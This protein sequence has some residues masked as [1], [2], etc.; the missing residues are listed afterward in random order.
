[1]RLVM[2]VPVFG[3]AD[4]GLGT[5]LPLAVVDSSGVAPG[6]V[7]KVSKSRRRPD[8]TLRSSSIR[9]AFVDIFSEALSMSVTARHRAVA[10]LTAALVS[11]T[12]IGLTASSAHA[13]PVSAPQSQILVAAQFRVAGAIG[14]KWKSL[15]G[16]KSFLGEPINSERRLKT[17]GAYQ[18]FQGGS[19][20]WSSRTGAHA[21]KGA[22]Q[23]TWA[24]AGWENGKYGYPTSDEYTTST[25]KAQR[26]QGGVITWTDPSKKPAPTGTRTYK[27]NGDAVIN[28]TKP[29]GISSV[30]AVQS[31][32]SGDSN[33]IV[34]G[35]DSN[36]ENTDL[37][38]NAIGSYT[39][40]ALLDESDWGNRTTQL[41]ITAE[42]PWT[43][44]V[45]STKVLPAYG[46]GQAVS[47][48]GDT[49]FRYTGANSTRQLTHSGS[50]NFIVWSYANVKDQMDRLLVNHTGRY[51][52][53]VTYPGPRLVEVTADGSWT[54]K[55]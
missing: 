48:K 46:A 11:T 10:V 49:V 41:E 50:R 4:A 44:T 34:W 3:P 24:R 16:S 33:F 14:A 39:G 27:G 1:M 17:G 42:G 19:I 6:V 55:P 38:V 8:W 31:S 28:I 35:L 12:G 53:R 13:A 23:R 30:A 52:G 45:K 36:Y 5:P 20:H 2:T 18:S 43:I 32:Y 26:F 40:T 7:T 54:I 37:L 29:D 22:I 25:G 15:G 51:S 21:T 47:G 9:F